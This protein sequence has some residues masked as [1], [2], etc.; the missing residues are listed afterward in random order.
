MEPRRPPSHV[1]GLRY[2]RAAARCLLQHHGSSGGVSHGLFWPLPGDATKGLIQNA[3]QVIQRTCKR[4]IANLC[5]LA[6]VNWLIWTCNS[7]Y[8][9]IVWVNIFLLKRQSWEIIFPL[10][11]WFFFCNQMSSTIN[12]R[13]WWGFFVC[14]FR[15]TIFR[16]HSIVWVNFGMGPEGTGGRLVGGSENG[17]LTLYNPDII[18]SSGADA[19]VG[20]SDKHTG[21]IRALDFNPFQVNLPSYLLYPKWMSVLLSVVHQI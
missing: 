17:I 13:A 3:K 19:V 7:S 18:M 11:P 21:P 14:F 9:R 20:Q 1:P 2:G 15:L 6:T 10:L 4:F 12:D 8:C 16:L 5:S